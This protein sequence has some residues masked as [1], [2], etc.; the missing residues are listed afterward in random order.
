M[1]LNIETWLES[2]KIPPQ[3][4]YLLNDAIICYK[5]KAFTAG[6]L[7]SYLGFL[8]ILKNRIL[9]ANKPSL[10]PQG[11]WDKLLRDIQLEDKWEASVFDAAVQ[12]EKIDQATKARTQ[13]PVFVVNDSIRVQIRYWKDRRND[14]AHNKDNEITNAHV[15]AFWSF[16]ISNLPKITVEGGK[17]ALLNKLTIFYDPNQTPAHALLN[18]LVQQIA[19]SVERVDLPGFWIDAF[20]I[21]DNAGDWFNYHSS[22]FIHEIFG[23]NDIYLSESLIAWLKGHGPLLLSYIDEHPEIIQRLSYE[24]HEIRALW[25]TKI[26]ARQKPLK[27]YAS[28]LRNNL[29]P[30]DQLNEANEIFASLKVY[31][32]DFADHSILAANGFGTALHDVLFVKSNPAN[33]LYWKFLNTHYLTIRQYIEFYPLADDVVEII[34]KEFMSSLPYYSFFLLAELERLFSAKSTKKDE[35]ITVATAKGIALP[36]LV[37]VFKPNPAVT[38]TTP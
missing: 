29:I 33:Y 16:L 26:P 6:M 37:Q 11:L 31:T 1:K 30:A 28:M 2:A 36:D 5:A 8:N 4:E 23:L 35:F 9:T 22:R 21:I 19:S 27:I 34:S 10:Y 7:M 38:T 32:D 24:A 3:A 18:P 15:E 20:Q 17:A 12:H 13:D 25:K 14:C